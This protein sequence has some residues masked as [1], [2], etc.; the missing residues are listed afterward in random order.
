MRDG[1]VEYEVG[2]RNPALQQTTSRRELHSFVGPER[3]GFNL[4]EPPLIR[5]LLHATASNEHLLAFSAD[6]LIMDARSISILF[7]DLWRLYG[8]LEFPNSRP[9]SHMSFGEWA[10]WERSHLAGARMARLRAFWEARLQDSGPFPDPN[11]PEVTD[12]RTEPPHV[13]VLRL[14]IARSTIA[15]TQRESAAQAT[16]YAVVSA[17]W[18]ATI[19]LAQFI[20]GSHNPSSEIATFS[21]FAN[22]IPSAVDGAIG[23]FANSVVISTPVHEKSTLIETVVREQRAIFLAQMHQDYP[24]ALIVRTLTPALYGIRYW[25]LPREMPRYMNFDFPEI[26]MKPLPQIDGLALTA[27]TIRSPEIPRGGMR[28]IVHRLN[29]DWELEIRY[30]AAIYA[31]ST[32]N[33]LSSLWTEIV[34]Y[35]PQDP[36]TTLGA[37]LKNRMSRIKG[38]EDVDTK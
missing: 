12:A 33:A 15:A 8:G 4:D 18:K 11:L 35:W 37:L 23:C 38:D 1:G 7:E 28:V 3:Q 6:H 16:H 29:T 17:L 10:Q 36:Q 2:L 22:R 13:G 26:S 21:A 5:F 31:T 9:G 27:K 14:R 32:M 19:R 24:H 34:T 30:N 25:G 20:L